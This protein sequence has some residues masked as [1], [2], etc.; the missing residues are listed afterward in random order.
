MPRKTTIATAAAAMVLAAGVATIATPSNAQE[1]G[2]RLAIVHALPDSSLVVTIDGREVAGASP[3]GEVV[4]PL[5]VSQGEHE[6]TFAEADGSFSVAATVDVA[7]GSSSDVV[8]HRPAEVG[9]DPVVSVY[10]TPSDPIGPGKARVLLAH[11]ATTAPADVSV[12]GEVVFTNIANGE[13]AVADVAAGAHRVSLLPSGVEADPILG[14]LDVSLTEGAVTMVYAVGNPR[15]GSMDVVVREAD[16]S[17]DGTS[18]PT[19]IET[20]SAGWA[21]LFDVVPFRSGH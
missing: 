1:A 18:A 13:Y 7:S 14:P 3:E 20:G 12:D 15:N 6:V 4:G 10:R 17:A 21:A 8:V 11:T 19:A 9:G 2:G 5:E 16:L